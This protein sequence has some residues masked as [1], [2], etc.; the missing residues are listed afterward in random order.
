MQM[1]RIEVT[2]KRA[3]P[4]GYY[5]CCSILRAF[6]PYIGLTVLLA[7]AAATIAYIKERKRVTEDQT[8]ESYQQAF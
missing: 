8:V 4:A 7:V 6:L 1:N 3:A 5:G 2:V